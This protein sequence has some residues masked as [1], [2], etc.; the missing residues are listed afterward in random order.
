[1]GGSVA[2]VLRG[3]RKPPPRPRPPSRK[4]QQ[5]RPTATRRLRGQPPSLP[6]RRESRPGTLAASRH[7]LPFATKTSCFDVAAPTRS[8]RL[9]TRPTTR[10]LPLLRAGPLPARVAS[11]PK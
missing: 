2:A 8:D 4:P 10:L 3:R 7:V 6:R 11:G 5:K 9:H 1:A